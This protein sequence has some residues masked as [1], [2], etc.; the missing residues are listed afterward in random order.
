MSNLHRTKGVIGP[1]TL[2]TSVALLL[3]AAAGCVV[4][5][6]HEQEE[7]EDLEGELQLP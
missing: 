6:D 7:Q 4:H 1:V 2:L 5:A 3:L